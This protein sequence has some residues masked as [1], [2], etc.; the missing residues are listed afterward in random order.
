MNVEHGVNGGT[1]VQQYKY[2]ARIRV[3]FFSDDV[4]VTSMMTLFHRVSRYVKQILLS[5]GPFNIV[6]CADIMRTYFK[7]TTE[8]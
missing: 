8:E 6:R 7:Y 4:R 1:A 3:Y 2:G 5:V